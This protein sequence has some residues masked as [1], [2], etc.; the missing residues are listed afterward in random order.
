MTIAARSSASAHALADATAIQASSVGVRLAV[1]A[2]VISLNSVEATTAFVARVMPDVIVHVVSPQ[3]P[4]ELHGGASAWTDLV[5]DV[6]LGVTLP[7]QAVLAARLAAAVARAQ[8]RCLF[9]NAAYPDSVNPVLGQLGLPVFCGLGNVA[10]LEAAIRTK[11]S[12]T[13]DSALRIIGHHC[14][15]SASRRFP[16]ARAWSGGRELRDV[17]ALLASVRAL[18]RAVTNSIA[19]TS[20]GALLRRLVADEPFSANL[21]GPRG[22]PGGYPVSVSRREISMDLPD[23][24]T[25]D[26]ARA[27]N[28]AWSRAEGAWVTSDGQVHLS[29]AVADALVRHG[30][31]DIADGFAAADL[32]GAAAE[33]AELRETLRGRC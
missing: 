32:E 1:G 30:L 21:P 16:E 8:P 18:P 6:G 4:S 22:L 11:L 25:I 2:E 12:L 13:S 24:V 17:T 31:P 20:G 5:R 10:V 15:L 33:L 27:L 3:S 7:L 29:E 14:H 26:E 28:E 19:A 9:V 23:E